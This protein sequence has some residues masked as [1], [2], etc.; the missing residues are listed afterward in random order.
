MVE[1]GRVSVI[2]PTYRRPDRVRI[3]AQSAASQTHPDVEVLVI[4]DGPDPVARAAVADLG[5][6]VR[7]FELPENRG[8]AA[9]RNFGVEQSRG[10]W[11]TFLDDDDL[12]LPECLERQAAQVDRNQP[13][14]ISACRIVYRHGGREDVWPHRPILAGEDIGDYILRRPSLL[15]RPGV[16]SLQSLLM[17][18]S[19]LREAPLTDH[20]DHEDWSWMLDAWHLAGARIRFV[21]EPLV[22]YNVD[23]EAASR[24]RRANWRDSLD[25][26]LTYRERL[27]REAFNSFLASKVALKARRAG[28]RE[29]LHQVFALLRRNR[30]SMLDLLFFSGISLLPG[31][32]THHAW[33]RSLTGSSPTQTSRTRS[34]ASESPAQPGNIAESGAIR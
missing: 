26:A 25:W 27:S 3:A 6:R 2:I 19:L 18:H 31:S 30:P 14:T 8:P 9:A 20:A 33:K 17:H 1:P 4:S 7:F 29:G 32:L 24:S 5:P 23:T 22:V 13:R 34:R 21:W 12:M 28:S 15:G 10:E 11:L 16:L